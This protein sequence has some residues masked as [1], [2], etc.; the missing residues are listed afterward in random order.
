[1]RFRNIFQNPMTRVLRDLSAARRRRT[2]WVHVGAVVMAMAGLS[3]CGDSQPASGSAGPAEGTVAESDASPQNV[4][5]L[6][7]VGMRFEGPHQIPA[8]WVTIRFENLSNMVHFALIDRLPP[9]VT[10]KEMASEVAAKFQRG[11]D[12]IAAGETESAMQVF[13]TFPE[14]FGDVV[15]LGGPGLLSG[16]ETAEAT[17]FLEPGEYMLECYIK[18]NGVFHSYNPQPG[19]LG[20]VH[21]LSVIGPAVSTAEPD[22]NFTLAISSEGFKSVEGE[23]RPGRN[24]I[25]AVFQD[26]KVYANF[27]RHDVH[28]LRIDEDT[29]LDAVGAWMDW[30]R[31]DGFETPAPAVFV[32]GLNEMPAGNTAYFSVDLAPG[33]YAFIAEVPSPAENGF[34]LPFTVKD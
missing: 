26:Q 30:S 22:A 2:L 8:G 14:W 7:A 11:M 33:R 9:G 6:R 21:G 13:G 16:G 17:V 23:L 32:G 15:F 25:R 28:V 3:G 10:P 12:L 27:V 1:M 19:E 5:E 18:T 31:P 24:M 4:L 34:L 20:M 29:D